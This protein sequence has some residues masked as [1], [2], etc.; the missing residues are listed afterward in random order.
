MKGG[1]REGGGVTFTSRPRAPRTA[2]VTAKKQLDQRGHRGLSITVL[3]ILPQS[4]DTRP[5]RGR[6][7]LS[8]VYSS[9]TERGQ[10]PLCQL[11][12]SRSLSLRGGLLW[13]TQGDVLFLFYFSGAGAQRFLQSQ[14]HSCSWSQE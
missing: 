12:W 6:N 13:D 8:P 11:G 4:T 7:L 10:W 2:K 1:R 14:R 9:L 3:S 5:L